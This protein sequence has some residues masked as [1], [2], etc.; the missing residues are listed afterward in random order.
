MDLL[1]RN[2]YFQNPYAFFGDGSATSVGGVTTSMKMSTDLLDAM[3][4]GIKDRKM[5]WASLPQ[6]YSPGEVFCICSPGSIYDLKREVSGSSYAANQ[7]V[8]IAQYADGTRLL[9]GEIGSY[10]GVRFI[11]SPLAILWN[12]GTVVSQTTITAAVSPGD[13]APNPSSTAVDTVRYVGQPGATHSITV[14]DSSGFTVNDRVTVH[15]LRG[16]GTN[17]L[18]VNN[19]LKWDDPMAQDMVIASIPDSTH[20]VF[21]EPYMMT[22]DLGAGL[23]ENLG[24]GVY[25]YVTKGRNI[26]TALFMN[27]MSS[28]GV[29]AGVTQAPRMYTPPPVDDY[30]SIYRVTYDMWMKYQLFQPQTFEIAFLA[31]SNREKGQVY[32]R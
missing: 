5:P 17:G 19:G 11:E 20:L 23:E 29:I 30:M 27:G 32:V 2:A 3:Q 28:E 31:G 10:R 13:G 24:G 12:A 14:A 15:Q 7:F 8:N 6:D 21:K 18:T 26:H 4:L 25:G 9:N 1:A 22:T 16:D